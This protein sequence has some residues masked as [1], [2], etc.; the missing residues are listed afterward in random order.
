[1]YDSIHLIIIPYPQRAVNIHNIASFSGFN[2]HLRHEAS[3]K[4]DAL[5]PNLAIPL[6]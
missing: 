3:I 4:I 2:S 1:M 6:D 5:M